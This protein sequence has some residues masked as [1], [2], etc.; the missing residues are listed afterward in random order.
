MTISKRACLGSHL[1]IQFFCWR[2]KQRLLLTLQ[3]SLGHNG[4]RNKTLKVA[5]HL[6]LNIKKNCGSYTYKV[7]STS[8]VMSAGT[9]TVTDSSVSTWFLSGFW[10]C[11]TDSSISGSLSGSRRYEW[12]G[13][14]RNG[15]R[16]IGYKKP[17]PFF[18]NI[19]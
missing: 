13:R 1:K 9:A 7:L 17:R 16:D 10:I 2:T 11:L 8:L 19:C 6:K 12:K 3:F 18:K 14:A 5:N 4:N 15:N